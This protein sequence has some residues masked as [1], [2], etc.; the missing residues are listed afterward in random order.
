MS[1]FC[2]MAKKHWKRIASSLLAVFALLPMWGQSTLIVESMNDLTGLRRGLI[3]DSFV[4]PQEVLDKELLR[5]EYASLD[6]DPAFKE[7]RS[8]GRWILQTGPSYARFCTEA[9]FRGDSLFVYYATDKSMLVRIGRR[10][11]DTHYVTLLDC[12]YT[13]RQSGRLTFTGRLVGDDYLYEEPI[14]QLSWDIRDSVKTICGHPCREAE[15]GFRG[16]KYTAY[17]AED[18]PVSYGPW[19]LQ[20]LPGLILEAYD[21]EGRIHFTAERIIP[22]EGTI[23]RAKYPYIRVTRKEYAQ[24]VQQMQEHYKVFAN[25]HIS[26]TKIIRVGLDDTPEPVRQACIPLERDQ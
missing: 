13:D 24:M 1:Y 10:T 18:I 23:S 19:K 3:W 2:S 6:V 26:R 14:P 22:L 9:R 25:N 4:Y 20:G 11:R 17:F 5:V 21:S 7:G 16:R 15:C 12:Y 8:Q